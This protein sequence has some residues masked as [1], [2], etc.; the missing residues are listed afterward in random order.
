MLA[1]SK[2]GT[3]QSSDVDSFG[4][5]HAAIYRFAIA[6]GAARGRMANSSAIVCYPTLCIG[7]PAFPYVMGGGWELFIRIRM[8]TAP[9]ADIVTLPYLTLPYP[10]LP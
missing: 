9:A 6:A 2:N 5:V 1:S 8:V 3:Q 4:L 7:A 10:T